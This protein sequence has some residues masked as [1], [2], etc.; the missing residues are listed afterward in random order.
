M[1]I[2]V[3]LNETIEAEIEIKLTATSITVIN[4]RI[5]EEHISFVLD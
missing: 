3:V 4:S 1:L 5:Y 2:L